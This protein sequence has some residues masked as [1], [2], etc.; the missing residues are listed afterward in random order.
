MAVSEVR[1]LPGAVVAQV[2]KREAVPLLVAQDL[3]ARAVLG[4]AIRAERRHH[5]RF[6]RLERRRH[7]AAICQHIIERDDRDVDCA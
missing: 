1:L 3:A 5:D 6:P 2:A 4:A 7:Q